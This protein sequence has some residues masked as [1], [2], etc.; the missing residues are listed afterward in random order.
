[1]RMAHKAALRALRT[2]AS[3]WWPALCSPSPI[4]FSMALHSLS[5]TNKDSH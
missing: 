4:S 2:Y 3:M 1:M 5:K